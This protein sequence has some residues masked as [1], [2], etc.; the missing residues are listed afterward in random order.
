MYE[1]VGKF[2]QQQIF[3]YESIQVP[4]PM[5]AMYSDDLKNFFMPLIYD[6][7]DEQLQESQL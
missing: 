2:M 1:Q 6:Q 5:F 7:A 3:V 4:L